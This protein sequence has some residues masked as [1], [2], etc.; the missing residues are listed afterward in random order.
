MYEQ[1]SILI[2][3]KLHIHS[4]GAVEESSLTTFL[5]V[6]VTSSS[7]MGQSIFLSALPSGGGGGG[8]LL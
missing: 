1:G 7:C 6:L 3:K 5:C 4:Y 8:D 2:V